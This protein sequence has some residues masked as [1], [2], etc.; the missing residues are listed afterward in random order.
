MS[1]FV[2]STT[3]KQDEGHFSHHFAFDPYSMGQKQNGDFEFEIEVYRK[4]S[5]CLW[6]CKHA[7]IAYLHYKH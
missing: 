4:M 2:H 7:E 1:Y 5:Q 6:G 3:Q